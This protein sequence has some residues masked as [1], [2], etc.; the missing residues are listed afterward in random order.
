MTDEP[1]TPDHPIPL[2]NP[3]FL[4]AAGNAAGTSTAVGV[5][6]WI[7]PLPE[8]NEFYKNVGR[9][10]SEW[11]HL[12]HIL[13][14]TIWKL[15]GMPENVSACITSQIMGVT[16]RC[17]AVMNLSRLRGIAEK[18]LAPYRSLKGDSYVIAEL[19]H[20]VVHDAWY[21]QM[22]AGTP[23]QFKAMPYSDPLHGYK[24]ISQS[25]ID[26]IIEKIKSLQERARLQHNDLLARLAA[27]Q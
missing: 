24:E 1:K 11:S 14:L 20:R 13:D 4:E 6:E 10:A 8:D 15:S 2:Q 23:L 7:T 25:E 27:L 17:N 9:V 16:G 19:R 18:E 12:E 21:A 3:V 5:G 26:H 22:P